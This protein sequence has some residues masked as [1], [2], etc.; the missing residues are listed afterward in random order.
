MPRSMINSRQG[1]VRPCARL[2][3]VVALLLS[4]STGIAGWTLGGV[5]LSPIRVIDTTTAPAPTGAHQTLTLTGGLHVIDQSGRNEIAMPM[6]WLSAHERN[7]GPADGLLTFRSDI[8]YRRFLNSDNH[9]GLFVGPMFR[10][11]HIASRNRR[12]STTRGAERYGAGLV[13]GYRKALRG[14]YW[15]GTSL[16]HGRYRGHMPD[17]NDDLSF[18]SARRNKRA[19]TNAFAELSLLSF[20]KRF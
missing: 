11:A 13:I 2:L 9:T 1:G 17:V 7:N 15:W 20:G 6:S 8:Q 16:T 12:N 4:A 5:E 14:N 18:V 19:R 10:F 3:L